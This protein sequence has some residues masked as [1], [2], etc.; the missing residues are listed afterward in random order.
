MRRLSA[1]LLTLLLP[2]AAAGQSVGND[3]AM[4]ERLLAQTPDQMTEVEPGVM[5]P[6][7]RGADGR[8]LTL[9]AAQTTGT[10]PFH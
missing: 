7:W 5:V 8:L 4:A 9:K 6:H 3:N 10:N 1:L 2:L